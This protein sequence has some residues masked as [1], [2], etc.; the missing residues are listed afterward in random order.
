MQLCVLTCV[1]GFCL[2]V[3]EL[4]KE[5]GDEQFDTLVL[6]QALGQVKTDVVD[7]KARN[8]SQTEASMEKGSGNSVEMKGEE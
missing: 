6:L 1:C 2:K 8:I 3:L 7:G 4:L 5:S